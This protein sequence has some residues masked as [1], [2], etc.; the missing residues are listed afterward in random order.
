M[1][2]LPLTRLGNFP[3][4]QPQSLIPG[5]FDSVPRNQNMSHYVVNLT[6]RTCKR[7]CIRIKLQAFNSHTQN[8]AHKLLPGIPTCFTVAPSANIYPTKPL[9]LTFPLTWPAL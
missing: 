8:T 9:F 2:L 4:S 3:Q 7:L 1:L 5:F 6:K